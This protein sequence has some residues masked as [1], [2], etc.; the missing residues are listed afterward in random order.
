M[1]RFP[2]MQKELKTQEKNTSAG[3]ERPAG[4]K[5]T[6]DH[7]KESFFPFKECVRGGARLRSREEPSNFVTR[8]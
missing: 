8:K 2:I 7:H 4:T 5:K 3:K 6:K 1:I